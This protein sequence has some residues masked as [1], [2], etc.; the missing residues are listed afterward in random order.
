MMGL[1]L[2]ELKAEAYRLWQ[3]MTIVYGVAHTP[4]QFKANMQHYGDLRYKATWERACVVLEA[5]IM[6]N[7]TTAPR[8]VIEYFS[9]PDTPIGLNYLDQVLDIVLSYPHALESIK[10]G[11]KQLYYDPMAPGDRQ[12]ALDFLKRISGYQE[13]GLELPTLSLAS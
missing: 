2:K 12:D 5:D 7:A 9:H 6:L 4:E 10:D 1:K 11:L 3:G 13:L 8:E